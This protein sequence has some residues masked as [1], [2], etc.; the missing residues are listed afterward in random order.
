MNEQE[1]YR[2]TFFD[3]ELPITKELR[4]MVKEY[5]EYHGDL[6]CRIVKVVRDEVG[7]PS[8][9]VRAKNY[10]GEK[11]SCIESNAGGYISEIA[12]APTEDEECLL[13]WFSGE[14]EDGDYDEQDD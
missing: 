2:P 9:L 14:K 12:S 3:M 5:H 13:C 10:K 6:S 8:L 4:Q 7:Y 11:I 1:P